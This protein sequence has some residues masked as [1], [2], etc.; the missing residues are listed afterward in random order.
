[1]NDVLDAQFVQQLRQLRQH[2]QAQASGQWQHYRP[3]GAVIDRAELTRQLQQA[4][5]DQQAGVTRGQWLSQQLQYEWLEALQRAY[6]VRQRTN[7]VECTALAAQRQQ[8][9]ARSGGRWHM[10]Q[11][12]YLK[13]LAQFTAG[14][15]DES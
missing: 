7:P 6:T 5:S 3:A 15:S 14:G 11:L 13:S 9:Q 4:V 10:Q 1:M 12:E 2:D 8:E